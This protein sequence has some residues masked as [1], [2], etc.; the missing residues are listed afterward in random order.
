[1]SKYIGIPEVLILI[2]V[3]LVA[4]GLYLVEPYLAPIVSGGI[5]LFMGLAL[6]RSEAKNGPS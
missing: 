5:I 6:A 2:G 4:G 1:M 3:A